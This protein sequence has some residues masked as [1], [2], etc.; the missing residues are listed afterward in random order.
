MNIAEVKVGLTGNDILSIINEFVK[1]E[2]LDLN[3][4]IIDEDIKIK[5]SYT[6]GIKIKFEGILKIKR[7]N[8]G[9]IDGE[10]LSF[11]ISK[12]KIA[13]ILRKATLKF[14]LKSLEDTGIKYEKGKIVIDIKYILKDINY[15]DL[16]ISDI[17]VK[18]DILYVDLSK[19]NVSLEGKIEKV[20]IPKE[21]EKI[22]E[23]LEV[24]NYDEII[25]VEDCYSKGRSY[26]E[27]KLPSKV[28]RFSNYILMIPDI[29]A[30]LI[31]LLKDNRV[32]IKT[33]LIISAAI[34]YIAFPIDIIP[35]NIP[36]IG[37]VDDVAVIF[38][39][40]SKIIDYVPCN[41]IVE[42]W[43]GKNDMI[44]MLKT[45]VEY[46]INFTGAKNVEK[47]YNFIEEVTVL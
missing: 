3:Q 21:E 10:I 24:I 30:L 44:S 43:Q 16:D 36:F 17:I 25:K 46:S 27:S 22:E 11:K 32:S 37:R 18:K 39:T 7:I 35:D 34:S 29:T 13:S 33:K 2:G 45:V 5:G 4:I 41:I 14:A 1:V 9:I 31:R 8:N 28:K 20:Y 15:V 42:N 26:I 12:L 6:K 38:F 40:I 47:I 23:T 19:L